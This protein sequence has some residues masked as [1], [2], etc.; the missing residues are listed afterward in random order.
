MSVYILLSAKSNLKQRS[1]YQ[2]TPSWE[3]QS[4]SNSTRI[5]HT[6]PDCCNFSRHLRIVAC[7]LQSTK[8]VLDFQGIQVILQ[9]EWT[10][11]PM[12][13]EGEILSTACS[14]SWSLLDRPHRTCKRMFVSQCVWKGWQQHVLLCLNNS[15]GHFGKASWGGW[16]WAAGLQLNDWIN[17]YK[18]IICM[19]RAKLALHLQSYCEATA[20]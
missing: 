4:Y 7:V 15:S 3:Q 13:K 5:I 14:S 16:I 20:I 1:W 10:G 8:P 9:H 11:A 6:P 17:R 19:Q 12:R 18:Q 2:Q